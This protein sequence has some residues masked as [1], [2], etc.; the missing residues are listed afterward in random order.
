MKMHFEPEMAGAPPFRRLF[1][2]A[3]VVEESRGLERVFHP[4][5]KHE[6]NPV[7]GKTN[8]WEGWGPCGINT[9]RD[10]R[11]LRMYYFCIG[12]HKELDQ[13]RRRRRGVERFNTEQHRDRLRS[14]NAGCA[15]AIGGQD[16]GL[17]DQ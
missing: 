16:L 14:G 2:D 8:D 4:A 5:V 7:F 9:V 6:G 13:A 15:P 10:G 3:M 11:T 17:S 1:L 12:G